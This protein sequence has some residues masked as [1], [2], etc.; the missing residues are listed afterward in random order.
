MTATVAT[1]PALASALSD[2]SESV[3]EVRNLLRRGEIA[4]AD[5]DDDDEAAVAAHHS[6]RSDIE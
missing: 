2:D 1:S 3:A 6:S 5:G 4:L